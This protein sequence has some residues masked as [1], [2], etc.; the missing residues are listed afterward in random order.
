MPTHWRLSVRKELYHFDVTLSKKFFFT[1]E[2]PIMICKRIL[3]GV[4]MRCLVR[5]YLI[6][7]FTFKDI[8]KQPP[9][10]AYPANPEEGFRF[11]ITGKLF[12]SNPATGITC[13]APTI[14]MIGQPTARQN[15]LITHEYLMFYVRL[16]PG[17][18]FKLFGIPMSMLIDQHIDATATV[19]KEIGEL[20][21]QLEACLTYNAMIRLVDTYFL[22][23]LRCFKARREPVD[24]IGTMILQNPQEFNLEKAAKEACL[25]Y[26][27]FE[28]RF[29]QLVGVTPKYYSR[30]CR[31]YEAFELKENNPKLDWLSVA[32]KVG[33]NDYQHLVKDFKE[34]AGTTPNVL[35]QQSLNSPSSMFASTSEFKGV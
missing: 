24:H 2:E 9:L 34:F 17:S 15:L 33:Y 11:L 22:K 35:I 1:K 13:E 16:Q 29:E 5:E 8:T 28:K 26:R 12:I 25:S 14:S 21:E 30:I 4:E 10:R 23:K 19:G 7:H 6:A 31:F 32:I 18:L 3:P 27:Q 20:Y